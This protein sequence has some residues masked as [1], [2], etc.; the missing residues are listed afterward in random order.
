MSYKMNFLRRRKYLVSVGNNIL[1]LCYYQKA[2]QK[3]ILTN[4]VLKKT[5]CLKKSSVY[6]LILFEK[7]M[8]Q[9]SYVIKT[10]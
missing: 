6:L 8:Q 1:H 5:V 2:K 7:E 10:M 3:R 4:F 9:I